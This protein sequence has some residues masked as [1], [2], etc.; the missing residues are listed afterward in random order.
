M[1]ANTLLTEACGV[2][3]AILCLL[4][5]SLFAGESKTKVDDSLQEETTVDDME[6]KDVAAEMKPGRTINGKGEFPIGKESYLINTEKVPDVV[7]A[8]A[9]AYKFPDKKFTV[10][11]APAENIGATL[12]FP[13]LAL[14]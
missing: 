5:H 4:G 8:D 12:E 10:D 3:V 9:K 7:I 2:I 13:G 1:F 6:T 11:C 14:P